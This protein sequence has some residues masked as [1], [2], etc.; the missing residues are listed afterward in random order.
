MGESTV[1]CLGGDVVTATGH[2]D[3]LERFDR[4]P[5]TD[6]VVLVGEIGGRS[7]LEAAAYLPAM[8][9]PVVAYV[10]GRHAPAGRRMGHAG[11]LLGSASEGA[12]A[13]IAA[14][15]RAG[16]AIAVEIADVGGLCR[17]RA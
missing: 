8:T 7:E 1:V 13:K 17:E 9:T 10:A 2:R 3:I 14:L 11:A 12:D 15:A 16:A 6:V 4:D 5:D